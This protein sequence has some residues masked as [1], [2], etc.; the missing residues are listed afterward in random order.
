MFSKNSAREWY[1]CNKL[2]FEILQWMGGLCW[3]DHIC[4]LHLISLMNPRITLT[5]SPNQQP[6]VLWVKEDTF[7]TLYK[8]REN[9]WCE[10]VDL[11]TSP[12]LLLIPWGNGKIIKSLRCFTDLGLCLY[13]CGAVIM[14]KTVQVVMAGHSRT[15][16]HIRCQWSLSSENCL[17]LCKLTNGQLSTHS[18]SLCNFY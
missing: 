9:V 7:F 14:Q 5:V 8:S 17:K 6:T 15:D 2:Y 13:I 3:D 16:C 18:W 1:T 4:V 12:G 11:S 10:D